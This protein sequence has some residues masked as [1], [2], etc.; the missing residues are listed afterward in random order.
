MCSVAY[1][2]D[3]IANPEVVVKNGAIGSIRRIDEIHVY[4]ARYF[5]NHAVALGPGITGKALAQH[6]KSLN[7]RLGPLFEAYRLPAGFPNRL[8][9]I[10]ACLSWGGRDREDDHVLSEADFAAWTPHDFDKF[11]AP[12]RGP[13]NR[14]RNPHNTWKP[15]APMPSTC[16]ACSP[17]CMGSSTWKSA[18]IALS[19]S[20][21]CI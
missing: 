19:T 5:D 16:R 2:I 8:C 18:T 4:V 10:A 15:G 1:N 3:R 14:R 21:K 12:R 17:H 13:W 7:E 11:V 9:I 6:L 20:G